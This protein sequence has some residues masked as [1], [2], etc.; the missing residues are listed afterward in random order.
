MNP[1]AQQYSSF[2]VN[3]AIVSLYTLSS[4]AASKR[5][6][7]TDVAEA[8]KA[9][10]ESEL[11]RQV[12]EF[13]AAHGGTIDLFRRITA[14]R[15]LLVSFFWGVCLG[16]RCCCCGGSFCSSVAG[17]VATLLCLILCGPRPALQRTKQKA[18]PTDVL[19][20]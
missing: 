1:A 20:G 2:P 19:L 5:Q 14:V 10:S 18:F 17:I 8:K 6:Q 3:V 9:V 11:R 13:K 7:N 15:F 4:R 12:E 16:R